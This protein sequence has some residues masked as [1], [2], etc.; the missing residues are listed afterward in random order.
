MAP[1]RFNRTLM[2][3]RGVAMGQ[4]FKGKGVHVGLGPMMFVVY[5][6]RRHSK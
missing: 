2:N 6:R 3:Q 5:F 1:I 4:E